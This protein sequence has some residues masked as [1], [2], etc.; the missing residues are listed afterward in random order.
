MAKPNDLK[1][2]L[3]AADRRRARRPAAAHET[4]STGTAFADSSSS[5]QVDVAG[6]CVA[7][8]LKMHGRKQFRDS[9]VI[10]ALRAVLDGG[11]PSSSEAQ[12]LHQRINAIALRDDV[13]PRAF[14]EAVTGLEKTATTHRTPDNDGAFMRFLTVLTS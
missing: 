9:E 3:K 7:E 6:L 14:R 10:T 2:K 4:S 11:T 1:R 8:I 5:T 12:L 13:S